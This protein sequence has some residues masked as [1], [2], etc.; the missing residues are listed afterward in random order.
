MSHRKD[1]D[2]L[3]VSTRIRAMENR[4]LTRERMD[5][6][7]EAREDGE[8]LKVLSECGYDVSNADT[9]EG[10]EQ[11]LSQ[12]RT[13]AFRD[14]RAN[15]PDPAVVEVFQMKYDYHNAKALVKAQAMGVGA[16]RL[17]VRGGRCDPGELAEA[18]YKENWR[19]M[20]EEFRRALTSAREALAE[21]G[22]PQQA[23]LIL[24]RACYQEMAAAAKAS[25]S[26]F[27]QGYVALSVDVANLRT[28]VR[29]ARLE[30]D[31]EFLS[32]VLLP[33]GS[34]SVKA[35]AAVRGE[36]LGALFQSGPLAQAA[37]LGAK[38]ARRGAGPLTA[39][40]RSCDDALT[41]YVS[42][43]RRVPFGE[44]AVVGYLYAKEAE[45]TAIRTIMAGRRA[46]LDGDTIRA[47]LRET[48]V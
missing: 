47:R 43:A 10:L 8:A 6:M 41:R 25:E 13:A 5:R 36:E 15:V 14:M 33:G 2:Y 38:A 12:A 26:R 46:G 42:A 1:T 34:V 44:E 40:E 27:L 22:D 37:A 16:D 32:R 35:I 9:G 4:L 21:S 29:A 20:G 18:F 24:D 39:F 23:D 48:Y 7:I 45:L 30:K 11:A 31:S 19:E 3:A 28:A 17:L